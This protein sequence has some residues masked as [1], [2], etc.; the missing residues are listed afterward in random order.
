M[1][2]IVK[3][4]QRRSPGQTRSIITAVGPVMP[5]LRP[6]LLLVGLL[7]TFNGSAAA[8][9]IRGRVLD[10]GSGEAI[11]A[12]SLVALGENRRPVSR[13]RTDADGAFVLQ[14]RAPG[15]Y[16][17]Q[18]ARTGYG[19]AVSQTVTLAAGETLEV[20][21]RLSVQPLAVEP[22]TVTA[23]REPPRVR[24]LEMNGFYRREALGFGKFLRREDV[25]PNRTMSVAQA[26]SRV[27][28]ARV[29]SAGAGREYVYFARAGMGGNVC[30]P[31]LYVD[32]VQVAYKFLSGMDINS[33]VQPDHIDAIEIYRSRLET[34]VQFQIAGAA[35]GVIVI[36]TRTSA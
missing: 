6:L 4:I 13:A 29:L 26:L 8:Q 9:T 7:C 14:L 23:R 2:H 25:A 22:L 28:G 33:S 21:L 1:L 10:A 20:E 31:L 18:G 32:G 16:S 36:W 24:A 3:T 12:A 34:P 17:I 19:T 15:T 11:P 35:C 30:L 5:S 27:Q